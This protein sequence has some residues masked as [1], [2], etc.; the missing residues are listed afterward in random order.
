MLTYEEYFQLD[1]LKDGHISVSKK[2]RASSKGDTTF[3]QF[4]DMKEDKNMFHNDLLEL[5]YKFWENQEEKAES[6]KKIWIDL[7]RKNA[8]GGVDQR[9]T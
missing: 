7:K 6:I 8:L 3:E 2:A 1:P 5:E 9:T 4:L